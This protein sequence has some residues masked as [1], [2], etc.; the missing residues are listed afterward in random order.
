[1]PDG[2]V[3]VAGSGELSFADAFQALTDHQP[4][5]WQS[6]LFERFLA[7]RIPGTCCIPTGLGKTSVIPIWLIALATQALEGGVRLPRRLIY[8][9]NRRTVVDQA[10]STVEQM[11]QRLLDPDNPKWGTG[12]KAL[13]HLVGLLGQLATTNEIPLAVS[14]LRGELA[15]NEEWKFDPARAA[16]IVGTI[17]MIGSKLLFS[18]YGDGP[19]RRTH[20]AGLVGQDAL[21]I[22]DEAHL[23]PPF[24]R[25]LREVEQIQKTDN[26]PRPLW[27]MELSATVRS[28][29]G[30]S[31]QLGPEDKEN[32]TVKQRLNATK[33]LR[34]HE[35]SDKGILATIVQQAT[36]H[37]GCSSKVLI[38]VR[39]PEDV[40]KV[41]DGLR[42]KLGKGNEAPVAV[43]T[44]TIRGYERNQLV[45]TD[46]VYRALLQPGSQVDETVYLVSTSA[47]EVGIDLDADHMVCDL[48]TL[49]SMI[50]RLG[51]INRR[52]GADRIAY[53]DVVGNTDVGT[54]KKQPIDEAI[55]N[56]AA[57]LRKWMGDGGQLDVSPCNLDRL[58]IH[59]RF[60]DEKRRAFSPEP[61]WP[62]LTD[63]LLDAWSLTSID[64]SMP[65]RPPVAPYLHGLTDDQPET[66][67]VWRQEVSLLDKAGVDK[68]TLERWFQ[69][70]RVEVHERLRDR[71]ERIRKA[72]GDLLRVHRK[73]DKS[74]DCPVVLLD[75]LGQAT[76][77]R[78]SRIT[79]SNI[80]Y[81]TVVLPTEAGGLSTQGMLDAKVTEAA[82]DVAEHGESKRQ[83]WVRIEISGD[84]QYKRLGAEE[85]ADALPQPLCERQAVILQEPSEDVGAE[86]VS[87]WLVLA[88]PARRSALDDPETARFEQALGAHHHLVEKYAD[89]MADALGLDPPLRNALVVAAQWHDRGKDRRLWQE[90][91]CNADPSQ[92]LA[93]SPKYKHG[94]FLGGYR[95]EFGSLV[96]ASSDPGLADHPERDLIL[97][98]IAAHHGRAR[99]HFEDRAYD[100]LPT[101]ITT[102]QQVALE[103]LRRFARLQ[104]QF[105]R[106]GLAWIESLLR[107]ADILASRS[108]KTEDNEERP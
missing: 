6:R 1:M 29:H 41:V 63:I 64:G 22:H 100:P 4:F 15:D 17:D 27:V 59:P 25:L 95:H 43:L 87:K 106:W 34:F 50:Q 3:P 72:L 45:K 8:I 48:S 94:C 57:L 65:G 73:T 77:S 83:R 85:T 26:E 13:Q 108:S 21:I 74:W 53:V 39:S 75:E 80:D 14:T 69:A 70:C 30:E 31:L 23:T 107:A 102:N 42:K 61:A 81:C 12:E 93:K 82:L 16:V 66:Y 91:A 54:K 24:G 19:C 10:T 37:E 51:R 76:W 5:P 79:D 99:P 101:T 58:M 68:A 78:L 18:G 46:R 47:G 33:L 35:V 90:Y 2:G 60:S 36:A 88:L 62:P 96:D 89:R 104:Q 44:G 9:V 71:T 105:G 11:R 97:H 40:Q 32:P 56:T 84:V 86:G 49:D 7:G 55:G 67:V 38:Y 28:D 52:G 98:L 20:H 103:T 92:T